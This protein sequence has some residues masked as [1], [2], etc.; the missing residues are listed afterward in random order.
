MLGKIEG[1]RRRGLYRRRWL[2]STNLMDLNLGKLWE[3][4][5]EREAWCA[6][7]HGVAKSQTRLSD[8]TTLGDLHYPEIKP[9]SLVSPVLAGGF[10]TTG[11]S[12][13]LPY[14]T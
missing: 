11:P 4:V 6:A 13:K 3:I 5:K 2:D 14:Y 8:S 10:F 7:V 1:K 12:E 9:A